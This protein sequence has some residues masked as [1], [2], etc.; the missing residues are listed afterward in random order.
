MTSLETLA[1]ELQLPKD[2]ANY[3]TFIPQG[4]SDNGSPLVIPASK[5]EK[6]YTQQLGRLTT[7]YHYNLVAKPIRKKRL[8]PYYNMLRGE[9]NLLYHQLLFLEEKI[10]KSLKKKHQESLRMLSS[11]IEFLSENKPK[12]NGFFLYIDDSRL[13]SDLLEESPKSRKLNIAYRLI[14]AKLDKLLSKRISFEEA[15]SKLSAIIQK[16]SK[17]VDSVSMNTPLTSLQSDFE[18]LIMAEV[19]PFADL[20]SKVIDSFYMGNSD[21]FISTIIELVSNILE[22]LRISYPNSESAVSFLL[23]RFIFSEV[24]PTNKYFI[25]DPDANETPKLWNLFKIE[26][27]YLPL[28]YFP[29][30]DLHKFPF[31]VFRLDPYYIMPISKFED[32]MFYTNPFDI[33]GVVCDTITEIEKCA[34]HYDSNQTLVFPF[35]VTFGLFLAVV[36]SSNVTNIFN[37]ADFVDFYTPRSGLSS[38]FEYAKAKIVA[39]AAH[40]QEL[41]YAKQN[42]ENNK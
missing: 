21:V 20:V 35:E 28:E 9:A 38:K 27:L 34:S 15:K 24:Y 37:L 2:V 10:Y 41:I 30:C 11:I 32:I 33:I 16:Q 6:I 25:V 22:F 29:K 36:F 26:E 31:E 17:L 3:V 7:F 23:Y 5:I 14:S 4:N 13:F 18:E 12:N 19:L 1:K 39:A 40:I 8:T 42:P